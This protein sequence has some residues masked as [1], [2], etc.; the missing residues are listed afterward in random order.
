[1]GVNIY[2][3][4]SCAVAKLVMNMWD[5]KLIILDTNRFLMEAKFR[6]MDDWRG[7]PRAMSP[8]SLSQG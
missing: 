4:L 1:M 5:R 2:L 6:P 3:K 8:G 7:L